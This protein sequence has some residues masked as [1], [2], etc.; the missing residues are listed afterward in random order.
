MPLGGPER[1]PGGYPAGKENA[2]P[3]RPPMIAF[4]AHLENTLVAPGAC[5]IYFYRRGYWRSQQYRKWPQQSL[6]HRVGARRS[7]VRLRRRSRNA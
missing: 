3:K 4:K 6:L 1:W 5:E 7:F 2:K